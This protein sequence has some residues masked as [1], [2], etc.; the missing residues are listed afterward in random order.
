MEKGAKYTP[1]LQLNCKKNGKFWWASGSAKKNQ[2]KNKFPASHL[3]LH[4]GQKD[5]LRETPSFA[6]R[7]GRELGFGRGWRCRRSRLCSRRL[8]GTH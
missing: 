8:G 3:C 5:E 1:K 6:L 4:I 7:L 2:Q